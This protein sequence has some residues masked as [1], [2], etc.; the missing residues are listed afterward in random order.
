M[1]HAPSADLEA[2]VWNPTDCPKR[3][4][5]RILEKRPYSIRATTHPSYSPKPTE[6]GTSH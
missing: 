5:I 6:A 3:T 2:E 4:K 1:I